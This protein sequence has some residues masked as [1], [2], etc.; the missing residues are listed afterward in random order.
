MWYHD[1]STLPVTEVKLVGE[2]GARMVVDHFLFD[3]RG[4]AKFLAGIHQS[5][6]R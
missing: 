1:K 6:V 3:F 5:L 2:N 4:R